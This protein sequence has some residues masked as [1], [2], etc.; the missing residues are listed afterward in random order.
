[1][2]LPIETVMPIW[3]IITIC[4]MVSFAIHAFENMGTQLLFQHN[5]V[6]CFLVFHTTPCFL[7][8]IFNNMSSMTLS[9]SGDMRAIAEC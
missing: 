8:V 2:P 6:I 7:S 5:Q 1:M 3:T 4:L 9:T